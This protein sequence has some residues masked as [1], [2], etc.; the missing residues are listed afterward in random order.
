MLEVS[1]TTLKSKLDA[2]DNFILL[3]VREPFEI[4]IASV[5]G[6]LCIPMNTV[7]QR[8]QELDP[9]AE[10]LVMCRSGKRSADITAFLMH[11]G[12]ANVHN[13]TGGI[14]AWATDVDPTVQKY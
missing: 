3:D 5:P 14:L 12:F 4:E 7:P 9:D 11:Q 8:V 1:V 10:I 2:G 13:V 6:A